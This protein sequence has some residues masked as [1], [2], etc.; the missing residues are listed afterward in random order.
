MNIFFEINSRILF[1][2]FNPKI[3]NFFWLLVFLFTMQNLHGQNFSKIENWSF[4]SGILV[5]EKS[6]TLPINGELVVNPKNG[7]GWN[8]GVEYDFFPNSKWSL[9]SGTFIEFIPLHD[10][11]VSISPLDHWPN[12]TEPLKVNF[13]TNTRNLSFPILVRK[14]LNFS[15]RSKLN[16]LLGV[17]LTW[18]GSSLGETFLITHSDF[19]ETRF[20]H[21]S[22]ITT[23]YTW[24]KTYTLGIALSRNFDRFFIRTNIFYR[25]SDNNFASGEYSFFN[26]LK[27]DESNGKI[28]LSG[29]NFCLS[30]SVGLLS[31]QFKRK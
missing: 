10:Y 29:N 2:G 1:F 13:R 18:N 14:S 30:L 22:I 7:V 15:E 19:G 21:H 3:S 12:E 8:F 24:F 27:S 11:K 26:L 16:F 4:S 20:I 25:F 5:F 6:Q 9:I 17:N 31:N 23:N 28:N